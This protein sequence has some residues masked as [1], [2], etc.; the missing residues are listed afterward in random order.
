MR[1]CPGDG[2]LK[3]PSIVWEFRKVGGS[4]L[5]TQVHLKY[6]LFHYTPSISDFTLNPF[7]TGPSTTLTQTSAWQPTAHLRAARKPRWGGVPQETKTSSGSLSGRRRKRESSREPQVTLYYHSA[8]TTVDV[9][10]AAP[11]SLALQV[12]TSFEWERQANK[13]WW[14]SHF[15]PMIHPIQRFHAHLNGWISA[16]CRRVNENREARFIWPFLRRPAELK[17]F[18]CRVA[19]IQV[20]LQPKWSPA[21][22]WSVIIV[23]CS[24]I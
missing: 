7:R 13:R 2:E 5:H 15:K 17:D 1:H 14:K 6:P 21:H 23:V 24:L 16:D 4:H 22:I 3:P 11:N 12:C 9:L 18:Y 19:F 8:I 10:F 20:P